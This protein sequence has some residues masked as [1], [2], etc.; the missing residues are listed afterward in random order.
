LA[1]TLLEH[2]IRDEGDYARHVDYIHFNPVKHGHVTRAADW[3]FSSIHRYIVA[4]MLTRD[5]GVGAD[6]RTDSLVNVDG[7]GVGFAALTPTYAEN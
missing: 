2:M 3:P 7:V 4:G 1:A 6:G 5:W